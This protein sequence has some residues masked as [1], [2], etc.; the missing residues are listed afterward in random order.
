MPFTILEHP[1]DVGL[2]ATGATLAEALEQA[3]AAL[4]AI[5]T[6]EEDVAEIATFDVDLTASGAEEQVVLLLQECLF[7]LDAEDF[8][9]TRASLQVDG[10]RV[11]GLLHG[12]PF[13]LSDGVHVKAITWHQLAAQV[14]PER[15]ELVVYVDI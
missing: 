13:D 2:R 9:A 10:D 7:L 4:A 11:H 3:V 14:E 6:G 5:E 1:A 8:L 12:G 15:A